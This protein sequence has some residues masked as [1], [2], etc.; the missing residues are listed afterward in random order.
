MLLDEKGEYTAVREIRKHI[1][2]YVKNMP[3]ASSFKCRINQTENK[4][5]FFK[6]VNSFFKNISV[7]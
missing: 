2:W 7:S 3:N 5:E 1:G 4:E 6:E